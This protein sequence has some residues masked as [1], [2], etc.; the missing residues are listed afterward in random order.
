MKLKL[1]LLLLVSSTASFALELNYSWK[2][3][4]S[5]QFSAV[6]KDDINM[7]MMGMNMTDKFTTTVDFVVYIQSVDA[8]G[9]AKG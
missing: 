3:F 9:T 6:Q 7:T 1:L 4:T 2:P 5:Y 8:E